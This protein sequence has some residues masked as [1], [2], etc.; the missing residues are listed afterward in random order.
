MRNPLGRARGTHVSHPCQYACPVSTSVHLIVNPA[1]GGGRAGRAAA[2]VVDALARL[3]GL[4]CAA[5]HPRPRPRARARAGGRAR[6]G[7]AVTLGGDGLAGAAA[8]ALRGVPGAILGVL[9]GGPRQRPGARA[10]HPADPARG[11]RGDRP[12]RP[13]RCSTSASSTSAPS[14]GSRAAASTA[15]PTGSPT[16]PL[17]GSAISCT[18]TARC[19]RCGRWR[20]AHLEVELVPLRRARHASPATASAPPTRR[21]TAAAC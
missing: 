4:R 2:A 14:W 15:T 17:R 13:A 3:M 1:A 6:G 19:A 5:R 16:T 10:R 12:R 18:P 20:P 21:P 8:D 9:P 7:A 11:V